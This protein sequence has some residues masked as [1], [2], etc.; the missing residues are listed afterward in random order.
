MADISGAIISATPAIAIV[1]LAIGLLGYAVA[2]GLAAFGNATD[3][4]AWPARLG[5][6]IADWIKENPACN[7]GIP[8]S[9]LASFAIV[10]GM[11]RVFGPQGTDGDL[12]LKAF[13]LDFTGPS[14]PVTLWLLCFL[15]FVF[16]LKLLGK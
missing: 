11:L 5:K 14:G 13:G 2:L 3:S 12:H 1:L 16:S 4:T 15:A 6:W 10:S 8:C 9:A 7:L